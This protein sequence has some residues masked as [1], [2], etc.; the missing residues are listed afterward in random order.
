[1]STKFRD[2]HHYDG[3]LPIILEKIFTKDEKLDLIK[4]LVP[5]LTN[6]LAQTMIYKIG[7]TIIDDGTD[8]FDDQNN[9]DASDILANILSKNYDEIL[10]LLE[11]QLI[12]MYNLGQCP[13]G[14]TTR[15]WQILKFLI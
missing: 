11:E 15:L 14:R 13:Q 2:V 4:L 7:K 9:I 12:D 3:K 10:E 5:K 6:P 1:M 8:N